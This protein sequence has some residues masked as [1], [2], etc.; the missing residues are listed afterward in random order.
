[1]HGSHIG[2][3][4]PGAL[5]WCSHL[6]ALG[7]CAGLGQFLNVLTNDYRLFVGSPVEGQAHKD[8]IRVKPVTMW[9]VGGVAAC[10]RC[11]ITC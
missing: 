10:P 1:M 2:Q 9:R 4:K 5:T 7:L 6:E 8:T 3:L 11:G